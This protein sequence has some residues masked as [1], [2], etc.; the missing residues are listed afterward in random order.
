MLAALVGALERDSPAELTRVLGARGPLLQRAIA[1][2]RALSLD[3]PVLA[4]WRRYQGVVWTHLAPSALR[5]SQRRRVLVPSGLLGL[6]CAEDPIADY[7]LTMNVAVAPLPTLSRFWRPTVSAALADYAQ[8][9]TIVNL[10][11]R[12]HTDALDLTA[13]AAR[14]TVINARFVAA[15]GRKAAGHDAKAVKGA[16]AA[17]L[18][19]DGVD[20]V[21][22][23]SWR[24][25]EIRR[26][27]D[28]LVVRAPR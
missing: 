6:V 22:R 23:A 17:R 21:V 13:A 18:V 19:S 5:P 28:E 16:L 10:L 12:E 25:W 27:G 2:T 9:A 11:P 7:R 14:A 3:P 8:G 4:A 15:D 1:T 26:E 24:G 20:A